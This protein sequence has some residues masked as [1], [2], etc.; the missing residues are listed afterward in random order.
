MWMIND[1]THNNMISSKQIKQNN[2]YCTP[3]K[4]YTRLQIGWNWA[5]M[6]QN[7]GFPEFIGHQMLINNTLGMIYVETDN[8][9][10]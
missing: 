5:K 3:Y 8:N 9:I 6:C 4:G 1:R 7:W 2:T 10:M